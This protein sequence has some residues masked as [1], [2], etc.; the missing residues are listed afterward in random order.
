MGLR[1]QY[2]ALSGVVFLAVVVRSYKVRKENVGAVI[3][4]HSPS[5]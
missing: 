4:H 2:L 3:F 1:G 5:G